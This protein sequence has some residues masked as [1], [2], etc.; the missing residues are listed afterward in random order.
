MKYLFDMT[1]VVNIE[2]HV[3][4]W[5]VHSESILADN[6]FH[7]QS[8]NIDVLDSEWEKKKESIFAISKENYDR[9]IYI[10][11]NFDAIKTTFVNYE[12]FINDY[13]WNIT[14][15]GTYKLFFQDS[16]DFLTL[17]KKTVEV[18]DI[19]IVAEIFIDEDYKIENNLSADSCVIDIGWQIWC[20]SV[21]AARKLKN[22]NIYSFEPLKE[23]FD[24]LNDNSKCYSSITAIN[25]WIS[26][27]NWESKIFISP[28]NVGAHSMI[29]NDSWLDYQEISTISLERVFSNFDISSVDLVKIDCEGMEYDILYNTPIDILQ[30]IKSIYMEVHFNDEIAKDHEKY[31]MVTFL[32]KNGFSVKILREFYYEWEWEFY[33]IQAFR[34]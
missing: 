15:N 22:A 9:Y 34:E 6:F 20:F 17:R 32:T 29:E 7:L 14:V 33:V 25:K 8:E 12:D 24:I 10:V 11:N 26:S 4:N 3:L 1:D 13:I 28:D 5:N 27:A 23:N 18:W 2:A 21:Y 31:D 19:D 16:D 30:R